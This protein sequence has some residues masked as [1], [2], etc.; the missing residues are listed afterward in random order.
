MM[1]DEYETIDNKNLAGNNFQRLIPIHGK[2]FP[3]RYL[4]TT[5]LVIHL[6]W[7]YSVAFVVPGLPELK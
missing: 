6:H 7:L 2:L 4:Y 3:D 5:D 1:N